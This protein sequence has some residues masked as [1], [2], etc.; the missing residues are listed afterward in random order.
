M[1]ISQ[2]QTNKYHS[3][4]YRRK[5]LKIS[6]S[7]RYRNINWQQYQKEGVRKRNGEIPEAEKRTREYV[8][9]ECQNDPSRQ[10]N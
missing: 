8:E 2:P 6:I 9:K 3:T 1:R 7:D 4:T 10:K 5:E